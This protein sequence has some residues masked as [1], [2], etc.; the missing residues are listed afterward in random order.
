MPREA[1]NERDSEDDAGG[2]R[3]EVLMR[4]AQHLHEIGHRA[5]AAVV[6]PVGV[7]DKADRRVEG[8]V[9]G[10]R[11]LFGGIEWQFC[12]NAHQ[13]IKNE[14]AADV[15]QQHGDRIADRVLLLALVDAGNFVDRPL[16]RP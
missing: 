6:L 1:A 5:F 8:E 3:Q 13:H 4:E 12:L 11:R 15:E 2:G 14:K 7:G 9:R 10:H 16:D